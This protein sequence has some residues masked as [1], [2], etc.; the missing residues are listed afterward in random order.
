M[1]YRHAVCFGINYTGTEHALRG[2]LNDA[3]DWSG[4]LRKHSFD[5]TVVAEA[6][7]TRNGIL[8]CIKDLIA[9]L[10]PGDTGVITYSGHGTW[11]P[12]GP[13]DEPDGQNEALCPF[14]MTDDG[15][16]LVMGTELGAIFNTIVDGATVVF[17][18]DSCHSG[19]VFRFMP[20]NGFD[21]M[22]IPRRRFLPPAHFIKDPAMYARMERAFTPSGGKHT[23]APLPNL[24]HISAC[25]DAEYAADAFID[26]RF[27]GAYTY[28]AL[29]A[30]T[31]QIAAG[32]TYQD[33]HKQLRKTLPSRAFPQ[34]P[35]LNAL[36]ILKAAK[37]LV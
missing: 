13:N 8:A 21:D 36:P 10:K 25:R 16:N 27:N 14:D 34:S 35:L 20:H 28:Y 6:N 31:A 5:T 24:I 11:V 23:N 7:A 1:K 37:V 12:G 4:F 30:F 2:C 33:V 32:G 29:Q 19:T 15:K 9:S 3:C 22:Y 18:T 26:G 17:L